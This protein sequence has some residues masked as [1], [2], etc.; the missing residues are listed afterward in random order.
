MAVRPTMY[1]MGYP[2]WNGPAQMPPPQQMQMPG[3]Y[4]QQPSYGP[5]MPPYYGNPNMYYPQGGPP[6]GP[7]AP[8]AYMPVIRQPAPSTT[9]TPKPAL[10]ITITAAPEPKPAAPKT[11]PLPAPPEVIDIDTPPRK[12]PSKRR[13]LEPEL[14][15]DPEE[16]PPTRR[17]STKESGK[18]GPTPRRAEPQSFA[19]ETGQKVGDWVTQYLK[20]N[21]QWEEKI[22]KLNVES[23]L[24][25]G[26]A[27]GDFTKVTESLGDVRDNFQKS[28]MARQAMKY[29][30]KP[31][32]HV[33]PGEMQPVAQQAIQW[34]T[35]KP[36]A[37]AS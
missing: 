26:L 17:T 8:I 35:T 6:M 7:G 32:V 15:E 3:M 28:W 21:P 2:S 23:F 12:A 11:E 20:D 22:K 9:P 19:E 10:P 1:P 24:K 5:P 37:G 4:P 16:A 18:T 27:N 36:A 29:L 30:A 31:L 14:L 33:L 34:L 25:N 13:E